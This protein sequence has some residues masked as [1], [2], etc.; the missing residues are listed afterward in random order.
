MFA[1]AVRIGLLFFIQI[2]AVLVQANPA[3][4]Q[5]TL[6]L[7][8]PWES[9]SEPGT[10]GLTVCGAVSFE[11]PGDAATRALAVTLKA[12][13]LTI[14]TFKQLWDHQHDVAISL[15]LRF[16][17]G[18]SVTLSG[19]GDHQNIKVPVPELLLADFLLS[20]ATENTLRVSFQG[21]DEPDW[22]VSLKGSKAAIEGMR[23]CDQDVRS[24]LAN[25]RPVQ[26]T[27][28]PA[29]AEYQGNLSKAAKNLALAAAAN[30]CRLRSNQ[31]FEVFN[32]AYQAFAISEANRLKLALTELKE[33]DTLLTN[34]YKET[35]SGTSCS[36]LLNSKTMA[37]LDGLHR[38]LT[39]GYH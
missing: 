17:T 24:G 4:A 30:M 15:A 9:H 26:P 29:F 16:N 35:I 21:I 28:R 37:E 25:P 11:T 3:L 12:E 32:T 22:L 23:K 31:W 39:G 13:G 6:R 5:N 38:T 7:W 34:V 27:K 8:D 10:N 1:I 14:T 20:L 33:S 19:R 2:A 18:D 36:K